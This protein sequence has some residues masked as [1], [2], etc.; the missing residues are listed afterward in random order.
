MA[1]VSSV[2]AVSK[3]VVCRRTL[4]L[5]ERTTRFLTDNSDWVSVCVLCRRA[6]SERGWVKASTRD[7]AAVS[8]HR[9]HLPRAPKLGGA[10]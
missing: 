9:Q 7:A 2:K 5:G 10:P 4:L 6:A 1:R 3:C 8:E